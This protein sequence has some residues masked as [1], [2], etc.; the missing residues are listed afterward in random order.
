[1]IQLYFG[2]G[3]GKTTASIGLAVR[4]AGHGQQVLF[5]QF[6]KGRDSGELKILRSVPWIRVLRADN[7]TRF[8]FEMDEEEKKL[9]AQINRQLLKE[10]FDPDEGS[11]VQIMILDEAVTAVHTG[12]LSGEQLK[13]QIRE[14]PKDREL[15][16]TGSMPE[17]WMIE[18]A[19]YVTEM[20]KIKHPFDL[21]IPAR[22]GIEY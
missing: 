14:W 20:K 15:I 3:K 18:M 21:G 17:K 11:D 7:S 13:E 9:A 19:D 12:L 8:T 22:E 6:M 10:A 16:L 1:M 4:A 2:D 5:V